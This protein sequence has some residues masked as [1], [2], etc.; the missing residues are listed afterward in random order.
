M[1]R[2]RRRREDDLTPEEAAAV[3]QSAHAADGTMSAD[4]LLFLQRTAGNQAL[5]RRLDEIARET[6]DTLRRRMGSLRTLADDY[7]L[8]RDG[9]RRYLADSGIFDR[10]EAD[11]TT[12]EVEERLRSYQFYADTRARKEDPKQRK[13]E[14]DPDFT[15]EGARRQLVRNPPNASQLDDVGLEQEDRDLFA[16]HAGDKAPPDGR[17]LGRVPFVAAHVIDGLEDLARK[18]A[19]KGRPR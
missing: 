16:P 14:P 19:K 13:E 2:A 11:G 5:A 15:V 8:A 4:D 10:D 3:E 12:G 17:L 18:R 1:S 9:T 6:D 7:S